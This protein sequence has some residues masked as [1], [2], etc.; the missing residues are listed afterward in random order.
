MGRLKHKIKPLRMFGIFMALITAVTCMLGSN[1]LNT[2]F[3]ENGTKYSVT[4]TGDGAGRATIT[5]NDEEHTITDGDYVCSLE[6]GTEVKLTLDADSTIASVKRN[7]EE[8]TGIPEGTSS[9]D[10]KDV[11][12]SEEI[13]YEVTFNKADDKTKED[14]NVAKSELIDEE[15]P[16]EEEVD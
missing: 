3:A 1:G 15:I 13:N 2:V 5:Y 10:K 14:S 4:I 11:V 16:E 6:E 12:A 9:Y 7:G 8:I